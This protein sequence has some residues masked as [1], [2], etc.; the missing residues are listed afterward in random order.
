MRKGRRPFPPTQT[1]PCC[2]SLGVPRLHARTGRAF[3]Q[4]AIALAQVHWPVVASV[5]PA[6]NRL[7][8]CRSYPAAERLNQDHPMPMLVLRGVSARTRWE[9]FGEAE[10]ELAEPDP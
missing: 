7:G 10:E 6:Q 3:G 2:T 9:S 1:H 5:A 8:P 4:I